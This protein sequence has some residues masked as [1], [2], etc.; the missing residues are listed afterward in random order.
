[1][2]FRLTEFASSPYCRMRTKFRGNVTPSSS[3]ETMRSFEMAM[4]WV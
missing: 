2:R 3:I 1:M 4:R